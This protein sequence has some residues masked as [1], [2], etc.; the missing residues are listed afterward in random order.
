MGTLHKKDNIQTLIC[1]ERAE[2]RH[3]GSQNKQGATP[4]LSMVPELPQLLQNFHPT[5]SLGEEKTSY[6]LSPI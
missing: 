2:N 4:M 3:F 5:A 6:Q 1:N